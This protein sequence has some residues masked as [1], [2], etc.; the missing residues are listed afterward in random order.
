ME[1]PNKITTTGDY[2][3]VYDSGYL[4]KKCIDK[5]GAVVAEYLTTM[6]GDAELCRLKKDIERLNT[7]YNGDKY[8]A[9]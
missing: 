5:L 7:K 8:D 4:E 3:Y 9:C 1:K 2:Y 6:D